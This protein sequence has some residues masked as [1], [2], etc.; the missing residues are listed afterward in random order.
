LQS[1]ARLVHYAER[2]QKH[3]ETLDHRQHV[4]ALAALAESSEIAR[5]LYNAVS[6]SL[7]NAAQR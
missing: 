5:R 4:E 3:L 2:V 7:K 6:E 1:A